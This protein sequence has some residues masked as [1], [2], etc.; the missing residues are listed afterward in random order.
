MLI[1]VR[2][3]AHRALYPK[4]CKLI[5]AILNRKGHRDTLRDPHLVFVVVVCCLQL[6][7]VSAITVRGVR[8]IRALS[9]LR[10]L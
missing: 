4:Q 8:I 3:Q 7:L 5:Q 10:I 2:L 6:T 1:A 9:L